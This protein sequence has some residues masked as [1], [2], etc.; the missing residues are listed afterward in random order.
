MRRTHAGRSAR[1]AGQRVLV[2][3]GGVSTAAGTVIAIVAEHRWL[4]R[5]D[6]TGPEHDREVGPDEI[7]DAAE[8]PPTNPPAPASQ[9]APSQ[10]PAPP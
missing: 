2:D 6:G 10:G 3:V 1:H 4:V 8:T 7:R 9:A 5:F